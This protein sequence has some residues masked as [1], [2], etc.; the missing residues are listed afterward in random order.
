MKP[1]A[2]IVCFS[3][4]L[5]GALFSQATITLQPGPTEGKDA[6]IWSLQPNSVYEDDLIRG[7]GWT[8]NGVYGIVRAFI[9]FDLSSIPAGSEIDSAFLSLYAPHSPHMQFHSGE[10]AAFLRRITSEWD[11]ATVSWN[12]QPLSTDVHQVVLPKASA[13]YQDYP[14]IN[15]TALI[16][17]MVHDPSNSFGFMLILQDERKYNRISFCASEYPDETKHPKLEIYYKTPDEKE[18]GQGEQL[19]IIFLPNPYTDFIKIQ[20]SKPVPSIRLQILDVVGRVLYDQDI[21]PALP[22]DMS[23]L[24]AALYVVRCL[25]VNGD[26]LG[27]AKMIKIQK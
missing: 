24:P 26:V 2:A 19:D 14:H 17:D 8:F 21:D 12:H 16:H 23:S 20:M 10:S 27:K 13:E 6:E 4:L 22:F 3:I 9:Q 11:D 25:D 5:Y 18:P 1:I 15:V 7:L